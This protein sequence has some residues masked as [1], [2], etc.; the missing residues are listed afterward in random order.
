MHAYVVRLDGVDADALMALGFV[1]W[2]GPYEDSWKV[3]P[4]IGRAHWQSP[5]R[6][7]L[8]A[9]G[10]KRLVVELFPDADVDTAAA[11]VKRFGATVQSFA[12]RHGNRRLTVDVNEP[13]VKELRRPPDVMFIEEAAEAQPRNATT[14][15]ICQSNMPDIVPLWDAGLHGEDQIAGIIDWDLR[16]DQ[17]AFQDETNPIGPLHRKIQA[18]YGMGINPG[19]GWHGT[20]VGGVLAADE[21]ANTEPDLKGMAYKARFVF[22]HYNGVTAGGV[23]YVNDRLTVAHSDGARVHSNSWGSDSTSEYNAWAR[24]IDLFTRNNEDDLVAVAVTNANA[25]VKVPENAKNCLAVAATQD[26]PYQD[27]RCYGGYGPTADGRQKPEVWA[28][29]CGSISAD[30]YTQCG[31]HTGGGTSYATPAVSGMAVLARQ[32]FMQGFYPGGTANPQHA[33]TPSGALLK[34]LMINSAEDMTG[35]DGYFSPQEGW[36]RI[37]MSDS[38]CLNGGARRLLTIDTRNADGLSTG[39]TDTYLVK[40]NGSGQRLKITLVW[41]DVPAALSAA[42]T[43]V[44]NLDLVVTDPGSI[45][46]LGNVFSNGESATGGSADALNNA[47]QVQRAA[48]SPGLWQVDVTGAAVNQD[49]Q[50]YAL[51]ITGDVAWQCLKGDVNQ[52]G[53]VD[54]ADIQPFISVLLNGGGRMEVCAA[55]MNSLNGPGV[56]DIPDFVAALLGN[57][58]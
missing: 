48:P 12:A 31:L 15:W 11:D 33:F 39:Q 9:L 37:L 5:E 29:G 16:A 41:T 3:S 56:D 43:P 23:L 49:L 30:Y 47:E 21:L 20:H 54:G 7:Q 35:F 57:G 4:D 10:K 52:D 22:Q 58:S 53:V 50:G 25:L 28:P 26:T 51:V 8:A 14:T 19:Y 40:V 44:N 42:F 36:G 24:D 27:L 34:A 46:Y 1:T 18:Y 32:Y 45:T 6:R 38:L 13:G 55:D 2:L 17:C